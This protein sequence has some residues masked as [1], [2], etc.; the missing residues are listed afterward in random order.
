MQAQTGFAP[1][2]SAQLYY[3]AAG[4]GQALLLL[5]AGV[6]D[7][8]MWDDQF[9]A[10]A[11]HYH[12]IRCD[13]RGFGRSAMPAGRFSHHDDVAGLLDY[14]QVEQAIVVGIS[15]GGKVALDLALAYPQRVA[16]L[17]LG[18]P[19]IGGATPSERIIQFWEDEETAV[20]K[21]DLDAAVELNLR[22]WV[23]GPHR[24]PG[25]VDTQLRQKVGQMQR[26]IFMMAVPEDAEE[27]RLLPAA[28]GRLAEIAA[29][30]LVLVGSLDLPE[31]VEQTAWLAEQLPRSQHTVIPGVAH[32]LNMEKPAEFNQLVLDFLQEKEG[33]PRGTE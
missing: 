24:Q 22:L 12:T 6:A 33:T 13:L 19:S 26:D 7:G 29:P 1:V 11:Q 31:M 3:E 23:D 16:A 9:A 15:F 20:A 5:H 25:E 21:G 10:F 18:A 14:L 32:M 2:N 28:Y 4:T 30:T 27:V 17:V 8:R